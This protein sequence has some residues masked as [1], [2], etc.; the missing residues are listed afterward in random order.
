[1]HHARFGLLD[2]CHVF[3]FGILIGILTGIFTFVPYVGALTGFVTALIIA[4]FQFSDW[5]P[6]LIVAAIFIV[7]QTIESYFLTPRLVGE[8]VGLHPVWIIF[9]LLAGGALFGFTGVLLAVPIAAIIGVLSRF[10]IL[11]Y[12]NSP[13]YD[14]RPK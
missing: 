3:H 1:M 11:R 8:G 7:G 14:D 10:L 2:F 13:L 4:F 5:M 6:L 12:L 9:A